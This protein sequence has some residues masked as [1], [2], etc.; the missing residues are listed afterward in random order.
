MRWLVL[1]FAAAVVSPSAAGAQERS[2]LETPDA[3][4]KVRVH[5]DGAVALS[6]LESE[7]FDFS[8][9]VVRVP[10]G[11]EVDAVVTDQQELDLI[12][13][14]AEVV[15]P[16]Q[17][18]KWKT[19]RRA[20]FAAPQ[21]VLP[22]PPEPTVRIVRADYFTTKG[23]G[24]LYVEAR[25]TQGEQ[26]NPTVGMTV[27][28]DQGPGTEF[29]SARTMSRFVD[30]GVYMFHRNLFKVAARPDKIRVS[31]STGGVAI[32][33]VSDWLRDVTPLTDTP[34]YQ[35]DFVDDYKTPQQVYGRFEQIAQQY[36]EIAEIVPLKNKTNGYQR[37]AQATI[38]GTG[39]AAVVISSAAWGQ[40]GGN[41][42]TV[43][44]VNRPGADLPLSVSVTGKAVRVLLAKD[45]AGA[46]AS[47]AAQVA[48]ALETSSGGLIDRAHPYRTNAGTGIVQAAAPTALTDFLDQK[49]VGAPA[50]DP[51]RGPYT[52]RALRIGKFRDGTKPGVLIQA[53]DHAREWVPITITLETA[54][55]LVR[56]YATDPDDQEDRRQHRHLPDPVQQPGRRELLVL[57]L[58]LP[59]AE[60]DQPL[61][62]RQRRPGAAQRV[63]RRPE[64]QLQRRVG[65]R[66]LRR[67]VDELHQRHL[68]GPRRAV[69]ARVAE[70]HRPRPAQPEHQVHDVRAL[71][72]R[73]AL[74][75]AGRLHR[76]RPDHDAAAAARARGVL[77]AVRRAASSRRCARSARRSSRRRT[78]AARRTSSIPPPATCARSCTSTTASSPSG[79]RSAARSTTPTPATSRRARSSRRG[80]ATRTS[81][82][83]T[84]RRWSTPTA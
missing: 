33:P 50:G 67:R 35:H 36:P 62:R 58:R 10:D 19:V 70:H 5:V 11:I 23:Q 29:I 3:V 84:A 43:E 12:A 31:S 22:R 66:R 28:N 26:T 21:A 53:N 4:K 38:G 51:P 41:A 52:I 47:T 74:L 80:S 54:E 15:E 14:G 17:E 2:P 30:S 9:G 34:G 24:F 16:G 27:E 13:R 68:P 81:S 55:R 60:H 25:T 46:L 71:Q 39:Q 32:G 82:A 57:Q 75:A 59:A 8:G 7:G 6:K 72:R 78:S 63:G 42:I 1:A 83:A 69:G 18:F 61:R 44:F 79:G 77:L 45:A 64:P 49:R 73:P 20:S 76:Q 37:K 56:N 65:L 40:D 48:A